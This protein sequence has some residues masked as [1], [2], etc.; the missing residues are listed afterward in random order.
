MRKVGGGYWLTGRA[1]ARAVAERLAQQ[2]YSHH[3]DPFACA[4]LYVALGKKAVLQG[5]FRLA[6]TDSARRMSEFLSRDFAEPAHR[7]AALKNAFAL[8]SQHRYE[9]AATFF[10]LGGSP[11]DCAG[12]LAHDHQDPQLALLVCRVVGGAEGDAALVDLVDSRLLPRARE[13]G[14]TWAEQA[15]LRMTGRLAE[16][17][18]LAQAARKEFREEGTGSWADLLQG[19][20]LVRQLL[21]PKGTALDLPNA[22]DLIDLLESLAQ[23]ARRVGLPHWAVAVSRGAATVAKGLQQAMARGEDKGD[24]DEEEEEAPAPP[25]AAVLAVALTQERLHRAKSVAL[26]P[27]ALQRLIGRPLAPAHGQAAEAACVE[28]VLAVQREHLRITHGLPPSQQLYAL[29]HTFLKAVSRLAA[30]ADTQPGKAGA[31]GSPDSRRA[32]RTSVASDPESDEE[33]TDTVPST[34][35]TSA[36]LAPSGS[37]VPPFAVDR[38]VVLRQSSEDRVLS[39]ACCAVARLLERPG[40]SSRLGR[41]RDVSGR[42]DTSRLLACC[43]SVYGLQYLPLGFN[44]QSR[45]QGP[46]EPGATAPIPTVAEAEESALGPATDSSEE[47]EEEDDAEGERTLD[48]FVHVDA[49]DA[50]PVPGAR[51]HPSGQVASVLGPEESGSSLGSPQASRRTSAATSTAGPDLRRN[52]S[53]LQLVQ[54]AFE[55]VISGS[56]LESHEQVSSEGLLVVSPSTPARSARRG[57]GRNSG[58]EPLRVNDHLSRSSSLSQRAQPQSPSRALLEQDISRGLQSR[59]MCAHPNRPIFATASSHVGR[60]LL[61]RFGD[62][63]PFA[64]LS[65][66]A[67]NLGGQSPRG[68]SGGHHHRSHHQHHGS[69]AGS[70][71]FP[72]TQ[73]EIL[74]HIVAF[75]WSGQGNRLACITNH[76]KA[77]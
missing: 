51:P 1:A 27:S 39:M 57:L 65:M 19:Q 42:G 29:A 24:D 26:V 2:S 21:G 74:G 23:K 18:A 14:D 50:A 61:W 37:L 8:L 20:E 59:A 40:I 4:L 31:S 5:L 63:S 49:G 41:I 60:A 13:Q 7:S 54:D 72:G 17:D 15:L 25:A 69:S 66:E 10:L 3:R 68:S 33:D 36:Y 75:R 62:D 28:R 9:L 58:T 45:R 16:A 73:R 32:R 64:A 77:S 6:S 22:L 71:R 34:M 47:D 48:D 12:V 30:S 11:K 38:A 70:A 56:G 55:S 46:G 43:S 44:G 35:A 52:I 53:F 67:G 76:G